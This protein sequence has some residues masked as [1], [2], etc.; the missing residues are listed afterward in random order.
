MFKEALKFL[1]FIAFVVITVLGAFTIRDYFYPAKVNEEN[2][3][4]IITQVEYHQIGSSSVVQLNN[5]WRATT[6]CGG[7][8]TFRK[9]VKVGDTIRIKIL[10][11]QNPDRIFK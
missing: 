4:C 2:K 3:I 10:K 1:G 7:T 8:Y 11:L 9:E 5:E 6:D